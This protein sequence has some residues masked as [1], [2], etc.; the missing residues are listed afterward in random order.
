MKRIAQ[1]LPVLLALLLQA[2]PLLKTIIA[3]PATGST[4][5]FILRWGI[6]GAASLGAYDTVSAASGTVMNTSS[7]I[8][9]TVGVFQ[10]N[11]INFVINGGNTADTASDYVFLNTKVNNTGSSSPLLFNG[12]TTTIALPSGLT[13]KC[14][15]V[16]NAANIYAALTGTPT[17]ALTTNI[18]ITAGYTG[19]YTFTT[20][21]QISIAAGG[22]TAPTISSQPT[23]V[24]NI[25]GSTVAFAVTASGTPTPNYQW[26]FNTSTVLAGAAN[27]LSLPQVRASQAGN[28]T[29]VI[30]NSSGAITSSVAVLAV[31]NPLPRV[32]TSPV[33]NG[34]GFQFTFV[35]VVGLTNTVQAN[36]AVASGTWTTFS[37]VPP[38]ASATPVTV[39]DS[40]GSSNKFYRVM[41][42]P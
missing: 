2:M 1:I 6:G 36:G 34:G 19:G 39:T 38:P 25:A 37:N 16:Q 20:N 23:G 28:Y 32:L 21:L 10:T 27:S 15:V 13:L 7:N 3:N 35:P 26:R 33:K 17:T 4:C 41:I 40:L 9:G 29:V 11:T 8:T 22:G 24:T 42:Q 31:T 12:Q 18:S 5:A 14:V 30:T